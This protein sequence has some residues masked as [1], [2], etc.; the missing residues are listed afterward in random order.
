MAAD[1]Q[2]VHY[3][4]A[5]QLFNEKR[6]V[7]QLTGAHSMYAYTRARKLPYLIYI[8]HSG[9]MDIN[10]QHG[11]EMGDRILQTTAQALMTET[12]EVYR[13]YDDKFIVQHEDWQAAHDLV[14]KVSNDLKNKRIVFRTS[15]GE[16]NHIHGIH[17]YYDVGD[18]F[19]YVENNVLINKF[20]WN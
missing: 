12:D 6:M 17:I 9:L 20:N 8:D 2:G 11:S 3:Q 14:F 4:V 19:I 18:E 13:H 10:L 7:D 15:K 16:L 1:E 5:K